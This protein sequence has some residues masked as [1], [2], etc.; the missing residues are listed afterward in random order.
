MENENSSFAPAISKHNKA[1]ADEIIVDIKDGKIT[2]EEALQEIAEIGVVTVDGKQV[3]AAVQEKAK[4]EVITYI[5]WHAEI[6]KRNN[7]RMQFINETYGKENPTVPEKTKRVFKIG[8]KLKFNK[9]KIFAILLVS[10]AFAHLMLLLNKHEFRDSETGI[11][12]YHFFDD[13][14]YSTLNIVYC[15]YFV[16]VILIILKVFDLKE[17]LNMNRQKE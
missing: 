17:G 15:L 2:Y 6:I 1:T 11:K 14:P 13:I 3:S 12:R 9:N 8:N 5:K 16:Y 10:T 4:S 7:T